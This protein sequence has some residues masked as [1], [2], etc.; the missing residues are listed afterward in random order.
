MSPLVPPVPFPRVLRGCFSTHVWSSAGILLSASPDAVASR[1]C[2]W[3]CTHL[4]FSSCQPGCPTLSGRSRLLLYRPDCD[5]SFSCKAVIFLY[6]EACCFFFFLLV[7]VGGLASAWISR[8]LPD[9]AAKM[10]GEKRL[11]ACTPAPAGAVKPPQAGRQAGRQPLGFLFLIGTHPPAGHHVSL[12]TLSHLGDG[13]HK[14]TGCPKGLCCAPTRTGATP[15]CTV[16][17]PQPFQSC[18][19]VAKKENPPGCNE[20][21]SLPHCNLP[22]K[23]A[24]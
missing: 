20:L 5:S 18:L 3:P 4:S 16:R 11:G 23:G 9:V 21:E 7:R 6:L 17:T 13:R 12:I 15:A 10:P 14:L 22:H 8:P 2:P 24:H 1:P 19:E